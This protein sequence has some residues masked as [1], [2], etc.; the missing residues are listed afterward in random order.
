MVLCLSIILYT[1]YFIKYKRGEQGWYSAC[2]PPHSCS[3]LLHL[4]ACKASQ[5]VHSPC[6]LYFILYTLYSMS[7]TH[8]AQN[9]VPIPARE[10]API[11]VPARLEHLHIGTPAEQQGRKASSSRQSTSLVVGSSCTCGWRYTQHWKPH[12]PSAV[13]GS[14]RDLR[15]GQ[16]IKAV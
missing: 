15:D 3:L 6:P 9:Q 7:C 10:K 11:S 2:S 4:F 12:P 1:L 5:R 16:M 13:G 8:P 14:G